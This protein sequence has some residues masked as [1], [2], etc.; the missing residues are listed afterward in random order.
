MA[1]PQKQSKIAGK[2]LW[3]INFDD[4]EEVAAL[5][6]EVEDECR[7]EDPD[8]EREHARQ[9]DAH[10]AAALAQLGVHLD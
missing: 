4:P 5:R 10:W 2:S 3:D 7:A 6:A 1:G 8:W 9:S